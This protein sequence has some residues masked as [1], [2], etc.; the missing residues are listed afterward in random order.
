[1]DLYLLLIVSTCVIG[2]ICQGLL[3]AILWGPNGLGEDVNFKNP[4]IYKSPLVKWFGML[5]RIFLIG[6]TLMIMFRPV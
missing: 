6:F 1:M 4:K 2:L 3:A 5:L